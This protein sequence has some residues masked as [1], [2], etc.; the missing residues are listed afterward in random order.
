MKTHR[1]LL[2]YVILAGL[3]TGNLM[4]Q[5]TQQTAIIKIDLDRQIGKVDPNICGAF[6]EPIRTVVYGTIYDP[7]S[8]LADTNGFRKDFIQL[9]NELKIPVVRWPGTGIESFGPRSCSSVPPGFVSPLCISELQQGLLPRSP[10]GGNL[11]IATG[12]PFSRLSWCHPLDAA[13][14]SGLRA[15][16]VS[17]LAPMEASSCPHKSCVA[18]ANTHWWKQSRLWELSAG[19]HLRFRWWSSAAAVPKTCL[20]PRVPSVPCSS[21]AW[22]RSAPPWPAATSG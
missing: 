18:D 5:P 4:S 6:V 9:V 12:N 20:S 7:K 21:L 1:L 15:I 14:P 16:G 11:D 13:A 22:W 10:V 2:G 19:V 17:E 8:P 3:M